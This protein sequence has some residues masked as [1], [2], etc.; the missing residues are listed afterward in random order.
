[1]QSIA[2][3]I[4]I[5]LFLYVYVGKNQHEIQNFLA[6]ASELKSQDAKRWFK[7]LKEL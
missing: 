1:M 5:T 7:F 3:K 2:M 4:C 6:S